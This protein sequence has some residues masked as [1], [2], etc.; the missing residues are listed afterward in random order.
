MPLPDDRMPNRG[1]V[2]AYPEAVL[3]FN[4]VEDQFKGEV[5]DKYQYSDESQDIRVHGWICEDL[6][7]GFW[8]ITPSYEFR[9]GGPNKQFL[10]SH[11]G[12][13]TLAMFTSAHYSGEELIPKF[14]DGEPWKKVLGPVFMYVNSLPKGKDP[15][16]LWDDAKEKMIE[17]VQSWPYSFPASEDFPKANERA[18]FVGRLFVHDRYLEDVKVP[19]KGAFVGLA[20]PG[21][22][23]SWQRDCKGY[24]F[25]TQTDQE[26]RFV[27]TNVHPGSYNLYGW[28]NGYIGDFKHDTLVNLTIGDDIDVGDLLFEPPRDGPTLWEIGEPERTAKEFFV[29]DPNPKY[30]NRL[31]VNHPDKFRQYGLWERYAELYPHGDLVYTVN[32]SDYRKDWFFAHVTRKV[33]NGYN[34]STWQVKFKLDIVDP[35]AVYKLRLALASATNAELE[36]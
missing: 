1:Q 26:G 18:T 19:A 9:A 4:P 16:L 15:R 32:V 7:T 6:V 12:P 22:V 34:G 3:L 23:G 11:V 25:W 20:I 24:Q 31:Y 13:T 14:A 30:I 35:K 2:L 28:V 27:I 33:G 10:T 8:Q 36:V 21:E 17:E 5:D 29:P